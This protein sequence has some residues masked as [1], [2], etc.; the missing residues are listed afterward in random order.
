M[1]NQ[2]EPALDALAQRKAQLVAQGA[3]YRSGISAA[4]QTISASLSVD[5]LA[6]SMLSHVVSAA[7]AVFRNRTGIGG[8]NLQTLLPLLVGTVST[9]SKRSLF[10]PVVRG[11][12]LLG[13]M[14]A[15][16]FVVKKSKARLSLDDGDAD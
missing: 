11:V 6:K 5:A 16:A 1:A 10:K 12:L 4:Q 7:Y 2:A 13:V 8:I 14:A 3:A 9:L 15:A